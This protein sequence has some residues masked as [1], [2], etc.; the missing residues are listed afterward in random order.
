MGANLI[1]NTTRIA[2]IAIAL[3]TIPMI[4]G[5]A[6][7]GL[8][9]NGR[10]QLEILYYQWIHN[11]IIRNIE[12]I[13]RAKDPH[14]RRDLVEDIEQIIYEKI[15]F[16]L[17]Y[18][19]AEV[20]DSFDL[21]RIGVTSDVTEGK[22][23]SA[24]APE[25][26]VAYALLGIAKGYEGFGAAAT[27]LFEKA[28]KI[29]TNVMN[30]TVSLDHNDDNRTLASWI[31]ASR[32]FWGDSSATRVTFWGKRVNQGTIDNLN[33]DNL[34]IVRVRKTPGYTEFVAR[35]DLVR[36]LRRYIVT[37][38]TLKERKSN[39]FSIYLPP[40]DYLLK[41]EVS[42]MIEVDF[43]VSRNVSANNYIVETLAEGISIYPIPDIAVFEE[44]MRKL[45]LEAQ[46]DQD[47]FLAPDDSGAS[48][49]SGPG[50]DDSL[51]EEE[52]PLED[53][54]PLE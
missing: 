13:K 24:V 51:M 34:A 28:K 2:I 40:G 49:D 38:D 12:E 11:D 46:G 41:S 39:N 19:Q 44:E 37:D 26:A 6:E 10:P 54:P 8:D 33:S 7:E 50:A 52:P 15:E 21:D 3:L 31:S 36:G 42:S 35:R 4:V 22:E 43:K 18:K 1:R 20:T 32:G 53:E 16:P 14:E 30:M 29:Y 25:I 5:A 17:M 9:E 48:V 23:A 27:D 47:D 45:R